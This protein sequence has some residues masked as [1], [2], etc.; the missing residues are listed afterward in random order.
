MGIFGHGGTTRSSK[1]VYTGVELTGKQ[2]HDLLE[3]LYRLMANAEHMRKCRAIYFSKIERDL[4]GEIEATGSDCE[5]D[6]QRQEGKGAGIPDQLFPI[7]LAKLN[8]LAAEITSI[9]MPVE[10][11]YTVAAGS[12]QDQKQLDGLAKALRYQGQQFFHR[13]NACATVRDAITLNFSGMEFNW[14]VRS[15]GQRLDE[16]NHHEIQGAE[17]KHLDAYNIG[18]D[19]SLSLAEAV[20]VGDAVYHIDEITGEKLLRTAKLGTNAAEHL[21]VTPEDLRV[22]N[23]FLAEGSFRL[24]RPE[25]RRTIF[26][27]DSQARAQGFSAIFSKA[28]GFDSFSSAG[29]AGSGRYGTHELTTVYARID[30]A[31]WGLM[32]VRKKNEAV[33]YK[34]YKFI[35]LNSGC[36]VQARPMGDADTPAPMALGSMD[37]DRDISRTSALGEQAGNMST[38]I[39]SMLNLHKRSIRASVGG[40]LIFY[41][42]SRFDLSDPDVQSGRIP[43]KQQAYNDPELGKYVKQLSSTIDTRSTLGTVE[44]L[45]GLL[46]GLIP[47]GARPDL[48]GLDRATTF[49]AMAVAATAPVVVLHLATLLDDQLFAPSRH[50]IRFFNLMNGDALEYIDDKSKQVLTLN[51]SE[52]KS[53]NFRMTASAVLTGVDKMRIS[54]LLRDAINITAQMG[55]QIPAASMPLLEHWLRLEGAGLDVDSYKTEVQA[56]QQQANE[57]AIALQ[58][59]SNQPPSG[60]PQVE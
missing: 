33:E 60:E 19:P 26:N 37:F 31:E 30:P 1:V 54:L 14:R 41:D 18:Y 11:P 17:L 49:H 56:L 6:K 44:D 27:Y 38:Y 52:I 15:T 40:G 47:E 21:Y 35:I 4:F 39:S 28:A 3:H 10:A 22:T 23:A 25:I 58:Q 9:I 51:K 29:V 46:N 57:Q 16:E 13:S 55:D 12:V 43:L 42:P 8:D 50:A 7:G 32:P 24:I 45:T 53:M 59:A 36:I 20:T 5:R 48:A 34:L 2:H